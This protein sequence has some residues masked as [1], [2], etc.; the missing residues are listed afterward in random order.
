MSIES[1]IKK[2]TNPKPV[3][4]IDF[5]FSKFT[6]DP[7]DLS[8]IVD[9]FKYLTPTNFTYEKVSRE[10]EKYEGVTVY[11]TDLVNQFSVRTIQAGKEVFI[12]DEQV[13]EIVKADGELNDK[14]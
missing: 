2:C 1:E 9:I 10:E 14:Q 5:H 3:T 6:I 8:R 11:K 12:S 7:K 13:E 4:I